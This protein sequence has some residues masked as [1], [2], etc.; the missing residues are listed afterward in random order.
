MVGICFQMQSIFQLFCNV[1]LPM[2]LWKNQ[3]DKPALCRPTAIFLLA[4]FR[5][6]WLQPQFNKSHI[7]ISSVQ[8]DI[9]FPFKVQE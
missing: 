6:L 9:I 8:A 5:I 3:G 7:N 2:E 4:V 1:F